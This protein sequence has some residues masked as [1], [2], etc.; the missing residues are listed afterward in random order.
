MRNVRAVSM[1]ER[2]I[3]DNADEINAR[4]NVV[5]GEATVRISSVIDDAL[6]S[7]GKPKIADRKLRIKV[8]R[9]G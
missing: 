9:V 4:I 1:G 5:A 7:S 2:I 8:F 3:E 6:P